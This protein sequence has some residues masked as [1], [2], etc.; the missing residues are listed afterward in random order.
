MCLEHTFQSA[1]E[2][3]GQDDAPILA[4]LEVA[5][6]KVGERPDVGCKIVGGLRHVGYPKLTHLFVQVNLV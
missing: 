3:K 6:K 4:L 1:K 5:A 2:R